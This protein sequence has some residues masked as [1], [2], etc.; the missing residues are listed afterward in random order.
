MAVQYGYKEMVCGPMVA[1]RMARMG[2]DLVDAL[3]NFTTSFFYPT[4]EQG[5]SREYDAAYLAVEQIDPAMT[6]TPVAVPA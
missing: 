4:L 6:G 3:A 5:G 1:A 2:H